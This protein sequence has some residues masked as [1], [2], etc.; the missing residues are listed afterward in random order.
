[1]S[2]LKS[3]YFAKNHCILFSM[4]KTNF[5]KF[6]NNEDFKRLK[7]Y[8]NEHININYYEFEKEMR[9]RIKSEHDRKK[10]IHK[11]IDT[12]FANRKSFT[13]RKTEL[14]KSF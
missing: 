3:S 10:I 6:L 11:A 4:N 13:K 14:I 9:N 8:R 5:E 7:K 2:C 12:S 1:M